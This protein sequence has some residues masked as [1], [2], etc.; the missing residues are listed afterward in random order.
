MTTLQVGSVN[1]S[2]CQNPNRVRVRCTQSKVYYQLEMSNFSYRYVL[3]TLLAKSQIRLLGIP[4]N[5]R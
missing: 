1:I 2:H 3:T 4:L 5:A